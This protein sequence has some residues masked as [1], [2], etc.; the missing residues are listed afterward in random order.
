MISNDFNSAV[1]IFVPSI[2]FPGQLT[3]AVYQRE[4]QVR[5]IRGRLALDGG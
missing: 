5:F 2:F 1:G 4:K 3:N